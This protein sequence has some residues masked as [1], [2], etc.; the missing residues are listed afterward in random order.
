MVFYEM[1]THVRTIQRLKQHQ[2]L[3]SGAGPPAG[4]LPPPARVLGRY[5]PQRPRHG[6]LRRSTG[7]R[8][9]NSLG[10]SAPHGR[11]H[12]RQVS[13]LQRTE[14]LLQVVLIVERPL[15]HQI[16]GLESPAVMKMPRTVARS[17][18]LRSRSNV[19][20][21]CIANISWSKRASIARNTPG[22]LCRVSAI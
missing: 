21:A 4:W 11:A 5:Q 9:E 17:T 16:I 1:L 19:A 2:G 6:T 7:K 20:L 22:T 13:A 14:N 15:V 12:V 3:S 18:R 10:Q 8:S